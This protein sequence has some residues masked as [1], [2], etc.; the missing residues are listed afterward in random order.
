M[1]KICRIVPIRLPVNCMTKLKEDIISGKGYMKRTVF[2]IVG[3]IGLTLGLTGCSY[4][5]DY[6]SSEIEKNFEEKLAV[7][8]DY[9]LYKDYSDM[10]DEN[11]YYNGSFNITDGDSSD[12][13]VNMDMLGLV[14]DEDTEPEEQDEHEGL[15][16]VTFASNEM[17]NVYYFKDALHTESVDEKDCWLAP[18]E[19]IYASEPMKTKKVTSNLFSFRTFRVC[20]IDKD[21]DYKTTFKNGKGAILTIPEN[22]SGMGYSIEPVGTYTQ[23][24]LFFTVYDSETDAEI[25]NVNWLVNGKPYDEGKGISPTEVYSVE[26]DFNIS[27]KGEYYVESTDPPL[28]NYSSDLSKVM[29]P[30]NS[31]ESGVDSYTLVLHR[32]L[33]ARFIG[34]LNGIKDNDAYTLKYK[35][36][37]S[38][39][40]ESISLDNNKCITG[41][42]VGDKLQVTVKKGF[43]AQCVPFETEHSPVNGEEQ[44]II[45]I[46]EVHDTHELLINICGDREKDTVEYSQVNV[47][48][49]KLTVA[50][51]D[52]GH[53]LEDGDYV[54]PQMKVKIT[55]TADSGYEIAEDRCWF[56]EHV[57]ENGQL[58]MTMTFDDYLKKLQNEILDG[59]PIRQK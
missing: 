24:K 25:S 26:C 45:T 52:G 30:Q 53:I 22:Y 56:K 5:N 2:S 23:R 27:G 10:L 29:F 14:G 18:G 20:N 57:K 48:H 16:R 50:M 28:D 36:R 9:L 39:K 1:R 3:I 44:Y 59:H 46:G 11:G 49:G 21:G 51:E 4:M 7:N 37:S 38:T 17:F 58:E 40:W 13:E 19:S 34:D 8:K 12:V 41:L 6:V 35:S 43:K 54:A 31:P 33:C 15:V 55:K 47:E 42:A 32:S